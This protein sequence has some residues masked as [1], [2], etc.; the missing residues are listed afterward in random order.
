[1]VKTL[2]GRFWVAPSPP[3]ARNLWHRLGVARVVLLAAGAVV[4]V[5]FL[6]AWLT[7]QADRPPLRINLLLPLL[8]GLIGLTRVRRAHIMRSPRSVVV[9]GLM[10]VALIAWGLSGLWLFAASAMQAA[11]KPFP[12]LGDFG[13]IAGGLLWT[14]AIWILYEGVTLDFLSEVEANAFLLSWMFVATLFVLSVAGG[15]DLLDVIKTGGSTFQIVALA[16]PIIYGCNAVMLARLVHGRI[17]TEDSP[18]RR[19]LAIIAVGLLLL[20]L[21]QVIWSST[22]I[23]EYRLSGEPPAA[24]TSDLPQAVFTLAYVVVALGIVSYPLP[25]AAATSPA[26]RDTRPSP[27]P[28]TQSESPPAPRPPARRART[29]AR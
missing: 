27:P 17:R 10:C 13:F 12:S 21:A 16:Y 20:Y 3:A 15:A 22:V 2:R 7:G 24:R 25:A 18:E 19:P 5:L 28:A 4:A 29:P 23:L 1:M 14:A 11:A 8:G 6:A 26:A 9:Y